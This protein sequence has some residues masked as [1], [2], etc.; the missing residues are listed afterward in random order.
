MALPAVIAALGV[1]ASLGSAGSQLAD[2]SNIQGTLAQKYQDNLVFPNDLIR[3]TDQETI[4]Y[5]TF[6]F[7]EYQ[8]R[9]IFEPPSIENRNGGSIRLPIPKNI[10]DVFSV[11]Y[12]QENL[13]GI[14][15]SIVEGIASGDQLRGGANA[16]TAAGMVGVQRGAEAIMR[17][18]GGLATVPAQVLASQGQAA[19]SGLQAIT[20]VAPNA[21]QTVLFKNPN[22]KKHQFSW[23]LVPRSEDESKTLKDITNTFQYHMLPGLSKTSSLFFSYPSMVNIFLNPTNKFLYKFKPCVVESFS[24]NYAPASSPAFFR[25]NLAPGAISISVTLQEIELWTKNDFLDPGYQNFQLPA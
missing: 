19:M 16:L 25:K 24:V 5:I 9:S 15:G 3:N 8:K 13:A 11:T 12:T 14:T 21:F 20:G 18:T 6:R 17:Q 4:P 10:Q 22:F 2:A 23:L 1:A 7:V